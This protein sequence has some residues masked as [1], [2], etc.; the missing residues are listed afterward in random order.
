[1]KRPRR[2]TQPAK[3]AQTQARPAAAYCTSVRYVTAAPGVCPGAQGQQGSLA[4]SPVRQLRHLLN[5]CSSRRPLLGKAGAGL[6]R[7]SAQHPLLAINSH[8]NPMHLPA[9]YLELPSLPPP[10][11]LVWGWGWGGCSAAV[12]QAQILL[13]PQCSI[14]TTG[15][16]WP[17]LASR[18]LVRSRQGRSHPG[19]TPSTGSMV[20]RLRMQETQIT[21]SSGGWGC[22]PRPMAWRGRS[23]PHVPAVGWRQTR[24]S[25]ACWAGGCVARAGAACANQRL[26]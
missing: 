17:L 24:P 4:T 22:P 7:S 19:P 16:Y 26:G 23:S 10:R 6:A 9:W 5:P 20:L 8:Y 25:R 11:R 2:R 14:S 21:P 18:P 15:G 13:S 3:Q 1:M 12:P